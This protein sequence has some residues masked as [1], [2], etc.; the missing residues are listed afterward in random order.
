MVVCRAEILAAIHRGDS[1]R[2]N[3]HVMLI[4]SSRKQNSNVMLI[5]SVDK[6]GC[7]IKKNKEIFN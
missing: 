7:M 5:S 1:D 2:E 4:Y 6:F 3:A